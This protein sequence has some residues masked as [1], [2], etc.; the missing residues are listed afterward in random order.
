M[1]RCTSMAGISVKE[2]EEVPVEPHVHVGGVVQAGTLVHSVD[3]GNVFSRELD[4]AGGH[5][6]TKA[7]RLGRLDE[8]DRLTLQVPGQDNLGGRLA[9][10]SSDLRDD[11][12]CQT[13]KIDEIVRALLPVTRANRGV[14]LEIDAP[15]AVEH[16]DLF[17]VE[18][19]VNLD[20]V[21]DGLYASVCKHIG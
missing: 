18:I 19:G 17:L 10:G 5:V 7:L 14:G 8:R 15:L 3:L 9:H 4:L 11:R 6:L 21:N 1:R 13:V 2:G 20:L 12:V 16:I